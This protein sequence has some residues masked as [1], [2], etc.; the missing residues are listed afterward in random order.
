MVLVDE[1]AESITTLDRAVLETWRPVGRLE[2]AAAVGPIVVVVVE[3]LDKHPTQVT[4]VADQ[5][6]VET[7]AADRADDAFGVGVRNRRPDRRQDHPYRFAREDRAEGARELRVAVADQ[8]PEPLEQAGDREVP[9]LLG[10]PGSGRVCVL[11]RFV[12]VA[13]V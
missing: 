7:L 10:D 3:V 4:L 1:A 12:D 13:A 11:E 2:R 9:C 8:E 5:G 6:P